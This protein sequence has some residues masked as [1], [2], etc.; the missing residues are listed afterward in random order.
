MIAALARSDS[1]HTEIAV[2]QKKCRATWLVCL[3]VVVVCAATVLPE[4]VVAAAHAATEVLSV[5]VAKSLEAAQEAIRKNDWSSALDNIKQAQ[6][7][8]NKTV[9]DN[10]NIDE[11][12]AYVLYRQNKYGEAAAVYERL[13]DSPLMPAKQ[14]DERTKAVAEM[15]FRL[16]DYPKAAKWAER[17]LER[18][19]DQPEVAEIL[20]DSYFRMNEYRTAAT[21]M[22]AAVETAERAKRIPEENEL[23]IIEDSYYRLSDMQ[24]MKSVL[25]KLVRYYH[26]SEDWSALIDLYSQ[27]VHD[28]RVALGYHR[29]MFDLDLLRR[30][31]DYE[32]MVFEA[33]NAGVPAE[34]LQALERGEK[35]GVFTGPHHVPGD[36]DRLLKMV[37]KKTAANRALLPRFA[38]KAMGAVSGQDDVLVGQIFLSY[39]QY[40]QAVDA[41]QRGILKGGEPDVDEAQLSLG[42]AYLKQGNKKLAN[43][44]FNAVR[45]DSPWTGL[46]E[47][48]MLRVEVVA[49]SFT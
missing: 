45:N 13:L 28:D 18:R 5:G 34:A 17:F 37:Q 27:N 40:D 46:A 36:Y 32:A 25:L 16:G 11:F 4:R 29:L 39:D 1:R 42:I 35:E 38:K 19:S 8:A 44:A 15:Y 2:T 49:G 31:D 24:G 14:V 9:K 23:R 10:Y 43:Q 41:L 21:M 20:A 48:W 30:P 12:L 6:S 26:Q 22:R 33:L 47:L 7:A 3:L